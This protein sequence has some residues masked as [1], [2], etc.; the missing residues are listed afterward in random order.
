MRIPWL[1]FFLIPAFARAD[2]LG[3]DVDVAVETGGA[4][5]LAI[6]VLE[7]VG[8]QALLAF[9]LAFVLL[10]AL[11]WLGRMFVTKLVDLAVARTKAAGE[12]AEG[13]RAVATAIEDLSKE[14]VRNRNIQL[15]GLKAVARQVGALGTAVD[16]LEMRCKDC[17]HGTERD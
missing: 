10:M 1:F 4:Y 16:E 7:K 6:L 15:Q 5:G 2:E 12:L 17:P 8:F 9:G 3:L 11:L 13:Q 14:V